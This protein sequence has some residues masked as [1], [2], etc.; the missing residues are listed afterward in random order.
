[1][2]ERDSRGSSD[3]YFSR[4]GSGI[5]YSM[6]AVKL[7]IRWASGVMQALAL[8][9]LFFGFTGMMFLDG[10]VFTHAMIGVACGVVAAAC[11]ADADDAP[12]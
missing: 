12:P 1:M 10:Q 8:L 3:V 4:R 5:I 11:G 2:V 7:T 6:S 9:S